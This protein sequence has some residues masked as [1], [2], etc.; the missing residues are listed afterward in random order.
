[1]QIKAEILVIILSQ[2]TTSISLL[3]FEPQISFD[4]PFAFVNPFF[5]LEILPKPGCFKTRFIFLPPTTT[6]EQ[7]S[8]F[9]IGTNIT[10][11]LI[12]N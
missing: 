12:S 10:R 7:Q 6:G 3:V 11:R 9:V 8:Q 5:L 1:M 2:H 4:N